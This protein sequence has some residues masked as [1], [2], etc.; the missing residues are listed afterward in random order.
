MKT[1]YTSLFILLF[2]ANAQ[3]QTSYPADSKKAATPTVIQSNQSF[4]ILK[5]Y[6]N[7]VKDEVTINLRSE[8]S[9]DVR[10]S[11]VNV[12]GSEVKKW[13][14]ILISEGERKLVLD[15]SSIKTGIYVL[16][17]TKS[18]QVVTQLLKK[19]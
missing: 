10:I 4:S 13:E 15:L 16:K 18:D 6:P 11:L 3:A 1:I 5:A 14:P 7:P 17:M 12:L 2:L 19:Y 9:G 8:K